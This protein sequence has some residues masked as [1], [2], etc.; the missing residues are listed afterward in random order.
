MEKF[1][2]LD[3]GARGGV[4]WPWENIKDQ[5]NQILIEADPDEAE[6]LK[7]TYKYNS[8]VKVLSYGL[9]NKSTKLKINIS[10][11]PGSSSVYKQNLK[12]L[13]RFPDYKRFETK[14]TTEIK[15]DKLDDVAIN[16]KLNADFI[17]IDIEGAELDAFKGGLNFIKENII[18]IESEVSFV[19]KNIDQPLFAEVDMYIRNNLD[20]ELFDINQKYWKYNRGKKYG[21]LKGRIIFADTIYLRPID[22]LPF[23]LNGMSKQ[24]AIHKFSSLLFSAYKYGFYDYVIELSEDPNLIKFHDKKIL[25]SILKKIKS[26]KLLN[27]SFK[28]SVRIY[29]FLLFLL[30]IFHPSHKKFGMVSSN[31][32]GNKIYRRL[33][34]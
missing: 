32:L 15:V 19:E 5:I 1:T 14:K 20:L 27:L 13:K 33:W 22:K 23:W 17:K 4:N 31:N 10:N 25:N 2:L 7:K 28:G 30:N 6:A 18:G 9:W 8:K 12:Y 29:N 11:S 24:K 34:F 3:V 21:S 26:K 16:E